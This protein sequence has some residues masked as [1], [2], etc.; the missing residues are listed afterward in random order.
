MSEALLRHW[1]PARRRN[2]H[3][4]KLQ[5]TIRERVC[6]HR[7]QESDPKKG[8]ADRAS[9]FDVV[10]CEDWVQTEWRVS[11]RSAKLVVGKSFLRWMRGPCVNTRWT[12]ITSS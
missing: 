11:A 7:P 4:P 10:S 1:R 9:Q 8:V 12:V 6:R 2:L 5:S 3:K